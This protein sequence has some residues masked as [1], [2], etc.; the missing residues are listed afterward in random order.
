MNTLSLNTLN[1][2]HDTNRKEGRKQ[3]QNC[4]STWETDGLGC[5]GSDVVSSAHCVLILQMDMRYSN[6][7]IFSLRMKS[8]QLQIQLLFMK[9]SRSNR[10]SILG[11]AGEFIFVLVFRAAHTLGIVSSFIAHCSVITLERF[12]KNPDLIQTLITTCPHPA[13]QSAE[14]IM[15]VNMC[16]GLCERVRESRSVRVRNTTHC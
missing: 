6:S 13:S 11:C 8:H 2:D 15:R 5:F 7:S 1:P 4:S 12:C 3:A 14:S 10:T 16:T 9:M